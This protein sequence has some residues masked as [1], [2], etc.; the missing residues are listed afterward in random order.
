M[1][2]TKCYK[3]FPKPGLNFLDIFPISGNPQTL[4]YVMDIFAKHL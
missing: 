2:A 3:D 4:Q 1:N